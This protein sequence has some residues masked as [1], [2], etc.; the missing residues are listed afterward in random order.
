MADGV[1]VD[2]PWSLCCLLLICLN[3]RDSERID[4]QD[5]MNDASTARDTK[6]LARFERAE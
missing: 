2:M 1:V 3:D 6:G 4:V 5:A